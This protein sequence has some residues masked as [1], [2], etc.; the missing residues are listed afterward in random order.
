VLTLRRFAVRTRRIECDLKVLA[1]TALLASALA[2]CGSSPSGGGKLGASATK[3]DAV[4]TMNAKG[5]IEALYQALPYAQPVTPASLARTVAILRKRLSAV[6]LPAYWVEPEQ[7]SG[8][9]GVLVIVAGLAAATKRVAEEG[10]G[11]SAQLYFYDW[12]P[13]VIGPSGQPAPADATVTGGGE[14]GQD[15]TGL[16]EYEAVL[17]AAKRPA[18][19]PPKNSDIATYAAGCTRHENE[20]TSGEDA[21]C[22]YGQWYLLDQNNQTV[23]RGPGAT[24]SGLLAEGTPVGAKLNVVHVNP[25]TVVVRALPEESPNGKVHLPN[26]WYVLNDNPALTGNDITDPQQSFQEGGDGA[27]DVIFGF[28]SKGREVFERVTREIA[29][30]GE[31]ARLPGEPNSAA[32]QHFAIMLDNQLLTV[33][34]I[35]YLENPQGIDA[36]YGSEITGG[37]TASSARALA[38]ELQAGA[39]PLKLELVSVRRTAAR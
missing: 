31:N 3:Q 23:L 38:S 6:P 39:L 9:P 10:L 21:G 1:A 4:A 18:I 22:V 11:K 24:R 12:E 36:T 14:A 17:G 32:F 2:S 20:A 5:G 15:R 29:R 27:P 13:N 8:R 30:R 34:Y 35:D 19:L 37:F 25:G 26:S 16:S 28:T 33:P 7:V